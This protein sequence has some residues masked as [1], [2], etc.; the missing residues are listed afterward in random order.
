MQSAESTYVNT[1]R[2]LA[3]FHRRISLTPPPLWRAPSSEVELEDSIAA[4]S[5]ALL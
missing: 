5:P 4:C 3:P 1:A 2:N